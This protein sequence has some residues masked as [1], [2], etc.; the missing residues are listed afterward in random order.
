MWLYN[1][2]SSIEIEKTKP[3]NGFNMNRHRAAEKDDEAEKTDR[4]QTKFS[5]IVLLSY[6]LFF[7]R[8]SGLRMMF[9][10]SITDIVP[11]ASYTFM[12]AQKR[13][14]VSW[15]FSSNILVISKYLHNKLRREDSNLTC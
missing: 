5:L 9:E 7:G 10:F 11:S 8:D 1:S 15:V 2:E 4:F 6:C 14:Y 3:R 12:S 13:R